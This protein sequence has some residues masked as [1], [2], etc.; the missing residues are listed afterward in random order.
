MKCM[1]DDCYN[2]L[3]GRQKMFCC[4][5]CRKRQSRTNK[6]NEDELGRTNPDKSDIIN[7]DKPKSDTTRTIPDTLTVDYQAKSIVKMAE[8][9]SPGINRALVEVRKEIASED[10]LEK[11]IVASGA[12]HLS[13]QCMH[14][15]QTRANNITYKR[16]HFVN[17]GTPKT[18]YQLLSGEHN[19]QTLPGDTDY[20]AGIETGGVALLE[21]IDAELATAT[22]TSHTGGKPK[23]VF[24]LEPGEIKQT[25]DGNDDFTTLTRRLKPHTGA[26]NT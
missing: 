15:K 19:R 20:V 3:T 23:T 17:H 10:K 9:A 4:D 24:P 21:M 5:K 7:P 1:N 22:T 11:E 12:L 26:L 2:V 14:C 8:S 16:H 13:C 18:S 6:T 25:L